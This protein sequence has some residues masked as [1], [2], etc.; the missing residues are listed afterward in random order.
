MFRYILWL[1]KCRTTNNLVNLY[2]TQIFTIYTDYSSDDCMYVNSAGQ[3]N[4]KLWIS[5][6]PIITYNGGK[7]QLKKSAVRPRPIADLPWNI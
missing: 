3:E 2:P 4:M 1:T 6:N 5:S 7:I